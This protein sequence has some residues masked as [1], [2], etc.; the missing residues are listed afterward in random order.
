[1]LKKVKGENERLLFSSENAIKLDLPQTMRSVLKA[2]FFP[3]LPKALIGRKELTED[4][5]SIGQDVVCVG[6][7][8]ES[9]LYIFRQAILGK[10]FW[11]FHQ[12]YDLMLS[13]P[14]IVL[15][16]PISLYLH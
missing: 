10:I 3:Q 8:G 7:G 15:Q 16:V 12:L 14:H 9:A 5:G 13:F 11:I 6:F 4:V 2:F 1:M